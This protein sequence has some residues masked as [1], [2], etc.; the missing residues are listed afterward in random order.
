MALPAKLVIGGIVAGAGLAYY[1]RQRHQRSGES[2]LDIVKQL[3]SLARTSV[4][5]LRRRATL[6][7]EDG[8]AAARAREDELVRQLGAAEAPTTNVYTSSN[9]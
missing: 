5:D 4:K 1:V 6:A 9:W 3:P 7:L 2:Y 8:K